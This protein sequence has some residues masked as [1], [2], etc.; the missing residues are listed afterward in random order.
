[1]RNP[2]VRA[3]LP[4][5][6]ALLAFGLIACALPVLAQNADRRGIEQ[7]MSSEEFKAAGLDKLSPDE[8][9]RLNAWLNRT[10]TTESEKAATLA[11]D[12]VESSTR[13]FFNFGKTDPIE[14]NMVDEFHGFARGRQYTLDNGQVW[15]QT[16]DASLA[17]VRLS[18]PHVRINP[19]LV[20]NAW[21]M[22]VKGYNTRAA[23]LR[24]K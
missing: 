17:G 5:L 1:M 16:D 19:S 22:S 24:V 7:Q 11:K 13:G 9:T 20:G 3:L 14:A 6:G 2:S 18:K 12:K 15:K 4:L 10:I 21:Y 8:L 23:V